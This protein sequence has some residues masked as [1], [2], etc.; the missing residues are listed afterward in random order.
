MASVAEILLAQGRHAAETRRARGG[1]WT[2][3][4]QSLANLPNQISADREASRQAAIAE[5]DAQQRRDLTSLQMARTAGELEDQD[6]ARTDAGRERQIRDAMLDVLNQPDI[7]TAE[8]FDLPRAR[9]Y[10]ESKG[11]GQLLAGA[12]I[13]AD[14]TEDAAALERGTKEATLARIRRQETE[15][16]TAARQTTNQ[17]GVR[18]MIGESVAARGGQPL[19]EADRQQ[20]AGM[21]FQE[22]VDLPQGLIPEPEQEFSVVVRGPGG[23]PVRRL[24]KASELRGG[25][26]EFREPTAAALPS[27]QAREVLNDA[28]EPITAN[29][30]PR[31]GRYTDAAG[32]VIRNPRPVPG[33]METQD[34][35]KFA[36]AGPILDSVEQLSERINTAQGL[37]ARMRGGAEKVAAQANYNDDVAEYQALVMGFTPLVARALGHT[38]VLTQQ[39]VDSVKALFPTPGDSKTL[40]DRKIARIRSIVGQLQSNAGGRPNAGGGGQPLNVDG[41]E[42]IEN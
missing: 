28:G 3:L 6:I 25:V 42:V 14:R 40:R 5:Q 32:Q 8:G 21:A 35:R 29:F 41:F 9:Q 12:L 30:D 31:T 1:V 24:V 4:V 11:Y 34:A 36:Q 26:E 16:E 15:A 37:I 13:E 39:D 10:A 17:Q 23:R 7:V 27:F 22:G 19:T 18:R 38:G 20:I 33:A 2:P